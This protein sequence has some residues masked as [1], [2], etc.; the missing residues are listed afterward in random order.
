MATQA[1]WLS[2]K[3]R[4]KRLPF[5]LEGQR[6]MMVNIAKL[7]FELGPETYEGAL[8][9][10]M[11]RVQFAAMNNTPVDTGYLKSTAR[12]EVKERGPQGAKGEV[13][14]HAPYAVAVH[15]RTVLQGQTY[16]GTGTK[17]LK[18]AIDSE[19][20]SMESQLGLEIR[21]RMFSKD[22]A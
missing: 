13:S 3:E 12:S 9:H 16:Q 22:M 18:R 21:D 4:L 20:P 1:R 5:S 15:E 10:M 6:E 7:A 17:Y 14:Y 8:L 2:R 11:Q 19:K